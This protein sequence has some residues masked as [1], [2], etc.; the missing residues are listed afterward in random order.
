[1]EDMES[2]QAIFLWPGKVSNEGIEIHFVEL[3]TEEVSLKS[4]TTKTGARFEIYLLKTD[5]R[6]P[7]CKTSFTQLTENREVELV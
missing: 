5:N 1:M 3:L 4:L 7:L 6:A 2:E